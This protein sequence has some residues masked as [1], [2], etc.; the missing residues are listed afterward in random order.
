MEVVNGLRY[1]GGLFLLVVWVVLVAGAVHTLTSDNARYPR[2]AGWIMVA[3][4]GWIMLATMNR[5]IRHLPAWLVYA[6]MG[7]CLRACGNNQSEH[8]SGSAG[9]PYLFLIYMILV[10]VPSALFA[11]SIA[12]RKL[13]TV[14][15]V[16]LFCLYP[17][18]LTAFL[19]AQWSYVLF[20]ALMLFCL[21]TPWLVDRLRRRRD[22]VARLERAE[23]V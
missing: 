11:G 15:R 3:L 23:T 1:V 20:P 6:A 5:W 16:L 21:A 22:H 14:D 9:T 7:G 2:F 19:R 12:K 17:A 13:T 10:T 4:A 18:F 8:A